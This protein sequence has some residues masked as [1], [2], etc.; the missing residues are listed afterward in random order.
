MNEVIRVTQTTPS[1]RYFNRELSWVAFNQRVLEEAQDESNP[2]LE[3]LRFLTIFHTNL[4][5][6]FM[7]RVS[8]LKQQVAAGIEMLTADGMTPRGNLNAVSETL[9]P[10]IEDA[11][12]CLHN[13]I[14]PALAREGY[15]R[16]PVV[17]RAV[18]MIAEA[19][20]SVPFVLYDGE[21]EL[22]RHPALD[23]LAAPNQMASGTAFLEE[24]YG[25]LL[26]AGNAY[27]E[28]ALIDGEQRCNVAESG[29]GALHHSIQRMSV[30]PSCLTWLQLYKVFLHYEQV[31]SSWRWPQQ[32]P[33]V[34]GAVGA[35]RDA[36]PAA[37]QPLPRKRQPQLSKQSL[38]AR[39]S[40][41]AQVK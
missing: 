38:Q 22:D 19:A 31:E 2:L 13:S 10:I 17:H 23:L 7:I 29:P 27:V 21:R 16:N 9:H 3:R 4:D 41:A 14:L 18:R 6:F 11:Q 36:V 25:H 20:A 40:R 35:K 26:V 34:V 5:E 32:L 12:A 8:G 24:V 33:G 39:G 1:P 15:A 28:A 30:T 37:A